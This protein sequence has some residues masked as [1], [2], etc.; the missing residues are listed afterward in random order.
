VSQGRSDAGKHRAKEPIIPLLL[1]QPDHF[2]TSGIGL[3]RG[4]E[5]E[6]N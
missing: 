5:L 3:S 6:E 4:M 1:A 2:L